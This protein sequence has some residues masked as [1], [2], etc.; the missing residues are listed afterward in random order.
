M[1]NILEDFYFGTIE[2]QKI[3]PLLSDK[4]KKTS[5]ELSEQEKQLSEKLSIK[6][7]EILLNFTNAYNELSNLGNLDSF[8]SGFKLGA[9]FTYEMFINNTTNN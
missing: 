2:P 4:F 6:D 9:R 3:N 7:R 5:K 8:I 1:S